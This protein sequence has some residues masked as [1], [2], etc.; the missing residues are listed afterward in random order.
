MPSV[1]FKV[2]QITFFSPHFSLTV[3]I[4]HCFF[5]LFPLWG[6]ISF[7]IF[8]NE[9]KIYAFCFCSRWNK[10]P[11][12]FSLTFLKFFL[13]PPCKNT[14]LP[15]S[16]FLLE[17]SSLFPVW[18]KTSCP[19]ACL[20][21]NKSPFFFSPAFVTL[22]RNT[23]LSSLRLHFSSLSFFLYKIKPQLSLF[24]RYPTT[25]IIYKVML[26]WCGLYW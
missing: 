24:F 7:I 14:I 2:K 4:Q 23:A 1:P 6:I 25:L 20:R 19:L 26:R 22:W 17:V 11:S 5:S 10:A 16:H 8:L 3:E 21:W 12:P 9:I 13:L 18:H 15:C